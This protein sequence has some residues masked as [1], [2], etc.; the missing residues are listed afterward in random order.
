M[1]KGDSVQWKLWI[2]AD[3]HFKDI[4]RLLMWHFKTEMVI[5]KSKISG[6]QMGKAKIID[7]N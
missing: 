4:I 5:I 2:F 6:G 1:Q 7:A 3:W